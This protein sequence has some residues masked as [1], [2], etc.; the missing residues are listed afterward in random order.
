[1]NNVEFRG[2]YEGY[3]YVVRINILG[4]RCGY[5]EISNTPFEGKNF[6]DYRKE[7]IDI[8]VH[9]GITFQGKFVGEGI[10]IDVHGGI[11][12]QG[13]FVGEGIECIGWDYAH[14]NDEP[15]PDEEFIEICNRIGWQEGKERKL[16]SINR[17]YSGDV[18]SLEDV[19]NDCIDVIKQLKAL[20]LK[21]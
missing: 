18:Y 8:D 13:K 6:Y 7:C 4:F 10:D 14:L 9:G 15:I 17:L 20:E 12:F 1:M 2:T 19:K 21:M 11:T 3:N 16:H 5:V